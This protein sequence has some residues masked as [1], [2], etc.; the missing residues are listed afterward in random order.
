[1]VDETVRDLPP[2]ARLGRHA[3]CVWVQ[4]VAPW[5][6][7]F[8]HR[9]APTG[10]AELICALGSAPRVL[11][12]H[13]GPTAATLEPGRTIVGVRLRP[14]ATAATLGLPASELVD[15]EIALDDLWRG[16]GERLGEAIAAARTPDAAAR[17][18]EAAVGARTPPDPLVAEAVRHLVADRR[19]ELFISDR[20]LRRR[21]KAATG[22]TPKTLHRILRFQRFL[23]L[24][25]TSDK[26]SA[27]LARLAAEAGYADQAH[28]TREAAR[29]EGRSPRVF[30]AESEQRCNC[31]H[32]H[33]ASYRPFL[34]TRDRPPLRV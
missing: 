16:A 33:A 26:P 12:P 18:L 31:G 7:S 4:E 28:L 30:L 5:S 3:T 2:S 11:G 23:A 34:V 14:E 29:L 13:T 6:T 8:E 17:T 21:F 19:P 24:A 25:W 15:Q 20:Q 1:M 27:E 32:D 10:S 22:L 9:R